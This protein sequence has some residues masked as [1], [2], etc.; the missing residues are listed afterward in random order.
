MCCFMNFV[1]ELCC[2]VCVYVCI[3]WYVMCVYVTKQRKGTTLY[4]N[5]KFTNFVLLLERKL[6]SFFTSFNI[7]HSVLNYRKRNNRA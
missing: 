3:V 1:W 7:A 4:K 6:Q 2:V 5:N